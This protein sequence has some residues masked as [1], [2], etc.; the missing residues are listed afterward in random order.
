MDKRTSQFKMGN[1]LYDQGK[2]SAITSLAIDTSMILFQIHPNANTL[3]VQVGDGDEDHRFW[4]R[5][6]Q[7]AGSNPRPTLRATTA[8][9][10][11]M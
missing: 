7:W 10:G 6:E 9:P 2:T 3:Y 5:P 8:L 4:G 11:I 1:G